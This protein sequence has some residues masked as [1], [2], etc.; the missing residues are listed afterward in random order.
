MNDVP[1][2]VLLL[3]EDD[4]VSRKLIR[5]VLGSKGYEIREADTMESARRILNEMRPAAV[6]LD[7]RL[8]D[9]DGLDL[10]RYIRAA[11]RLSQVPIIA[12]TAQALKGDEQRILEAGC[13]T[14]LSKPIDTR[15]LPRVVDGFVQKG[16]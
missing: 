16:R 9:G 13:D 1:T 15:A 12:I 14:Y 6:L 10:A 11:P 3:V 5:A 4:E 7:M 2:P 8:K